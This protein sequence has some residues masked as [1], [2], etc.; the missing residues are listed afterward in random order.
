MERK[1]VN[2]RDDRVKHAGVSYKAFDGTL[3]NIIQF[4]SITRIAREIL[5]CIEYSYHPTNITKF[6][7]SLLEL[8]LIEK[9]KPDKPNSKNQKYRKVS[10]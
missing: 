3:K 6:I 7:K 10:S 1:G 5:E 8:S 9:T 4:C 2:D